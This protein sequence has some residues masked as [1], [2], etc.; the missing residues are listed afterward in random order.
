MSQPMTTC[1]NILGAKLSH[2]FVINDF[3][4]TLRVLVVGMF[5]IFEYTVKKD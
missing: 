5:G 3:P 1:C 4:Q 2:N